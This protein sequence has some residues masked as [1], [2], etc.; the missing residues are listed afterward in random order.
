MASGGRE[1]SCGKIPWVLRSNQDRL[2]RKIDKI[3][4]FFNK[5]DFSV[6][7]YDTVNRVLDSSLVFGIR[8]VCAELQSDHLD[9]RWTV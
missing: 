8:L 2:S 7:F 9:E 3:G 4:G 1:S 5:Q 6:R